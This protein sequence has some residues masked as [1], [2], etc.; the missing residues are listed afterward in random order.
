MEREAKTK[1]RVQV[2]I[3]GGG[4]VGTLTARELARYE[5]DVLLLEKEAEVGWGTTKANSGIVHA[6]IHEEPGT[7]KAK[8]CFP[9]NQMYPKLC[10]ELDVSFRQNGILVVALSEEEMDTVRMYYQRGL[11]RGVPVR[12]LTREEVLAQEPNLNP[13]VVGAVFAPE[14]GAVMP[15]ELAAAAMENAV[16]NGVQLMVD[17]PVINAWAEGEQKYLETPTHVIEADVVINA[18]GLFAD[19][20]ARMFG[21]DSFS[22]LPRKGEEYLFD[23]QLEGMVHSTLFP[24]PRSKTSKGILVIPTA[25]GNLMIGPTS[26]DMPV[27]D[28]IGT[29]AEAFERIFSESRRM[30]PGLDPRKIITQFA[31]VRAASD[32]GDFVIEFSP[33]VPGLLH[34]AGIESP[35]L[36]AAPAIAAD[37]PKMLQ[38][39]GLNLVPKSGFEPRREKVVR[40]RLLSREEQDELIRQNPAYGRMVCRCETVTEAEIVDAIKRGARTL[41]GVKFRTRAGAGRCQSGFCQ[42]VI[43]SILSRELGI[44]M[45][46]VSKRGAGTEQVNFKAKEL[47]GKGVC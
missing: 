25:D 10:E 41:D 3:V 6:G 32:R 37:V 13:E 9:G 14:G 16:A 29:T 36:T 11:K 39:Y 34:L 12:L 22:I 31:G 44:P 4:I 46:Q 33:K 7:L 21:D 23:A 45:E 2:A 5:L 35:G 17:S 26:D 40:F 47:L 28:D 8:Y 43:M 20:I 15:F 1:K 38:E 42:P 24:V 19:D 27:K 18:A 30:V